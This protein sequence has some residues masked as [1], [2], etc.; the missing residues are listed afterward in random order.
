MKFLW[1]GDYYGQKSNP[2]Q[3]NNSIYENNFRGNSQQVLN[4][5]IIYDPDCANLWDNN[6]LGNYWSDYVGEDSDGD[7]IGDGPIRYRLQQH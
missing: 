5:H 2:F 6:V 7:G 3:M 4:A 1:L